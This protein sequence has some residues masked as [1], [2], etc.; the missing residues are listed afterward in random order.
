MG[1]WL[2]GSVNLMEVSGLSPICG[3]VLAGAG[4]GRVTG[5]AICSKLPCC[6]T[7]SFGESENNL[8][9]MVMAVG[10]G[11]GAGAGA[12]IGRGGAVALGGAPI[13]CEYHW[14]K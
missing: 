7:E 13:I 2:T 11:A 12:G 5:T 4:S 6:F 9:A 1:L 3:A 14:A 10:A 8:S